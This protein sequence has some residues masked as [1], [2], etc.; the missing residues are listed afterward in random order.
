V[1]GSDLTR[2][3]S[4]ASGDYQTTLTGS[5]IVWGTAP[6]TSGYLTEGVI[7]VGSLMIPVNSKGQPYVCG[8]FLGNNA[9][10]CGYGTVNGKA[11]TAMGQRVTQENDYT[12]R[13]GIGVQ[14][15]WGATAYKNA[16]LVK[17]G[18]IV[19]YGAWNAPGMPEVS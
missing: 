5:T 18:Y 19:D 6:W 12:N 3:G 13:F 8:Y 7:P 10:Y 15:V 17:N 4:T 11:S 14:M 1:G 9:V 2:L 16:A